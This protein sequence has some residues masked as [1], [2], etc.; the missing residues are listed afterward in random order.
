[1]VSAPI[2]YPTDMKDKKEMNL[3]ERE[4]ELLAKYENDPR[5]TITN[6]EKSA[7]RFKV[8]YRAF[9]GTGSAS[10]IYDMAADLAE[11]I[12]NVKKAN[13]RMKELGIL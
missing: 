8:S 6:I 9:S 11:T 1:M 7:V 3:T 5:Y 13:K 10:L 2:C 4:T 12:A